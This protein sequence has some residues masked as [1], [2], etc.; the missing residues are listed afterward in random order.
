MTNKKLT[1]LQYIINKTFKNNE[2]NRNMVLLEKNRLNIG[3]SNIFE[4]IFGDELIIYTDNSKTIITDNWT[5]F[6]IKYSTNNDELYEDISMNV[7]K[8]KNSNLDTNA[9]IK[10]IK[11]YISPEEK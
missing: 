10:F 3:L 8:T 7:K 6:K 2:Y 11:A 1:D 9:I 5:S 4:S